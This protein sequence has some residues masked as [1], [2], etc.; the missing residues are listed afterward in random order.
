[1]PF[2]LAILIAGLWAA[3]M[4]P[5]FFDD[6]GRGSKATTRDFAKRKRLLGELAAAQPEGDAYVRHHAQLRRQRILIGLGTTAFL[7]LVVATITGSVAWLSIAIAADLAIAAF[8]ALLLYTQQQARIPRATVVP[9]TSAASVD[10][11]S[12]L[13]AVPQDEQT[14]TVRVI[15]G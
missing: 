8:V 13:V 12:P 15:A 7:T 4:L 5:A 3:F 1:M 10:A 14:T 2:V 6:R 11:P 9:I